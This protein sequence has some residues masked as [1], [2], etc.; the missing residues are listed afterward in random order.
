M[1]LVI[2][3][4]VD[5]PDIIIL[6]AAGFMFCGPIVY[7]VLVYKNTKIPGVDAVTSWLQKLLNVAPTD[8]KD[9]I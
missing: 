5:N 7:F 2:A 1:Y 3:P 4:L 8:W 9:D 6:Y